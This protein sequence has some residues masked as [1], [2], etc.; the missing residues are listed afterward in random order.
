MKLI[1]KK[2]L[3][4]LL[5]GSI[6]YGTGGGGSPQL[7]KKIYQ[8]LPKN[9]PIKLKSLN[10]FKSDNLFITTYTVGGLSQQLIKK[11]IINQAQL[12]YQKCLNKKIFGIIPVEIGPLS[13]AL[14]IKMASNLNLPLVDADFVGGRSTPE[15]FLETIT[16]FNLPR[17]P[18]LVINNQGK[19]QILK[20]SKSYLEEE[21]FLR[22]FAEKSGGF[23]LVLGYP[24]TQQMASKTLVTKTVSLAI[25]TGKKLNQKKPVGQL[26]FQGKIYEIKL[27]NQG[28]FTTKLIKIKNNNILAKLYLKNENLIFWLDNKPVLTCPDL[29]ILLDQNNMPIFNLDLKLN[30][31][32]SVV[33]LPAAD[34]WRSQKGLKLFNPQLFGFNYKPKLLS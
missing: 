25:K 27:L 19:Y 15:V 4:N 8:S 1:S 14:A 7:A 23:A 34:L 13:L 6:F 20:K 18:L 28:S 11:S 21:L 30:Q 17:T 10:E 12:I 22:K 33:G 31:K 32:I 29:I 9:Q 2:D 26:L 24:I 5:T 3:F 16:L